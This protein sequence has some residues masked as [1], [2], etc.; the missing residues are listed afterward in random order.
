MNLSKLRKAIDGFLLKTEPI[1]KHRSHLEWKESDGFAPVIFRAAIKRQYESLNSIVAMSRTDNG[2]SMVS[3][4]R[5]ACEELIWIKYLKHIG[6]EDANELL[7]MMAVVEIGK[8]IEAQCDHYCGGKVDSSAPCCTVRGV[9]PTGDGL[10]SAHPHAHRRVWVRALGSRHFHQKL[11]RHA[12]PNRGI[13]L[14]PAA[15]SVCHHAASHGYN[16]KKPDSH[17]RR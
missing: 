15:R 17:L 9:C 10:H 6:L 14:L 12:R 1:T 5:P 11:S 7:R 8:T 16:M 3:L 2:Y 4:L 13:S